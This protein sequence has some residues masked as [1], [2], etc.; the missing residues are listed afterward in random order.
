ML[1]EIL[2][3]ITFDDTLKGRE[4]PLV[5]GAHAFQVLHQI[6]WSLPIGHI[7]T[8]YIGGSTILY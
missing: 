2:N 8:S 3:I 1:R 7:Y 6:R 5:S 4:D